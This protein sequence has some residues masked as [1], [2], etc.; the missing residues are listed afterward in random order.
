MFDHAPPTA[1]EV[2]ALAHQLLT[3]ADQLSVRP[4]PASALSEEDRRELALTRAEAAREEAWLRSQVFAGIPFGNANWDIMLELFIREMT[5][6][7][8]SV[9]DLVDGNHRPRELVIRCVDALEE[10][11][12]AGRNFDRFD[13]RLAWLSLTPDGKQGM[14]RFLLDSAGFVRPRAEGP[15]VAGSSGQNGEETPA[16]LSHSA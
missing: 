12:L 10:L 16:S 1:G 11:G 13:R 4:V 14:V 6:F 3:W 9:G 2:R 5:G 8:V 7:R 15:G